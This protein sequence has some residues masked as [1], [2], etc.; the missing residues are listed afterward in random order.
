MARLYKAHVSDMASDGM[1]HSIASQ[2]EPRWP[3]LANTASLIT[4]CLRA[5][6]SLPWHL[7]SV[8]HT[9]PAVS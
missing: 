9:M 4:V 1:G 7:C 5:F 2:N 3:L 6:Q 8:L